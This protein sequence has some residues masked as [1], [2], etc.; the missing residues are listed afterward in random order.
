VTAK[1]RIIG[2]VPRFENFV[3]IKKIDAEDVS[4]E[5]DDFKVEVERRLKSMQEQID[6]L[7]E[8]VE[9]IERNDE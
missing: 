3:T 6:S 2:T 5:L 4:N 7:K 8:T 1:K 9:E